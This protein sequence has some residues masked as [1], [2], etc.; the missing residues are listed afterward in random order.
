MNGKVKYLTVGELR[1]YLDKSTLTDDCL[2]IFKE[3]E[4]K[5]TIVRKVEKTSMNGK[6]ILRMVK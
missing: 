6:F 5:S 4:R 2:V 3:H 1:D